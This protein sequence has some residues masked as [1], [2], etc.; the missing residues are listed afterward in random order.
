M[1][2]WLPNSLTLTHH[3]LQTADIMNGDFTD[4]TQ[5]ACTGDL[6]F[7][8]PPFYHLD[9]E[10]AKMSYNTIAESIVDLWRRVKDEMD[11]L[12]TIGVYVIIT[13]SSHQYIRNLFHVYN[14]EE[15]VRLRMRSQNR[16][17]VVDLIITNY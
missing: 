14:I 6:V 3:L 15:V 17:A 1:K 4:A 2:N 13:A 7:M 16:T 10:T 11:R 12:S 9:W 8:D 5:L